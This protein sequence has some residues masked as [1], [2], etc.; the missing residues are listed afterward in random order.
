MVTFGTFQLQK[1]MRG[2]FIYFHQNCG[3]IY[4]AACSAH[5]LNPD[6]GSHYH[7]DLCAPKAYPPPLINNRMCVYLIQ[8]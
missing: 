8:D 1:K 2:H 7:A 3:N 5:G 6:L 4:E